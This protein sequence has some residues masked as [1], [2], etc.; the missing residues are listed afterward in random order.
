MSTLF[1]SKDYN[2]I[3]AGANEYY[4]DAEELTDAKNAAKS[5]FDSNNFKNRLNVFKGMATFQAICLSPAILG[6]VVDNQ[7]ATD[8][9]NQSRFIMLKAHV[10]E[11]HSI[12]GNPCDILDTKIAYDLKKQAIINSIKNHPWF[13]GDIN[14]QTNSISRLPSFGDI[15]R[16]SFQKNPSGGRMMYGVYKGIVQ[17]SKTQS[18]EDQCKETL[19][20]TFNSLPII[21]LGNAK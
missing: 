19:S 11:L 8:P 17:S 9:T 4:F 16:V 18:I 21:T 20:E 5:F 14:V 1:E 7:R 13:I 6:A 12:I 15:V 10:P 3:D 2:F